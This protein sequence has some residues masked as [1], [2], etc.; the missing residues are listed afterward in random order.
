M[1]E[2]NSFG[3]NPSGIIV[4]YFLIVNI[5]SGIINAPPNKALPIPITKMPTI[6]KPAMIG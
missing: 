1:I 6:A 3:V 4:F 5:N 2:A